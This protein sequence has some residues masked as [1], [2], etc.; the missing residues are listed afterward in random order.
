MRSL[1]SF[2]GVADW[3][4]DFLSHGAS[5]SQQIRNRLT[6]SVRL[7]GVIPDGWRPREADEFAVG[8]RQLNREEVLKP[9]RKI[10]AEHLNSTPMACV[11]VE[12]L[13]A[14][15]AD[16]CGEGNLPWIVVPSKPREELYW[17][18][19]RRSQITD[20]DAIL[21]AATSRRFLAVLSTWEGEPP[22]LCGIVASE[23]L[24][25]AAA[26]AV[27]LIAEIFDGE[28]YL[29]AQFDNGQTL[30]RK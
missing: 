1:E 23:V 24:V 5:L 17:I 14:T 26:R 30:L 19:D 18:A 20:P 11:L 15:R 27:A 6:E 9:L 4:A 8:G 21:G 13:W 22:P 16:P 28:S 3:L 29:V 25:V 12:D 2:P 7:V 10:V